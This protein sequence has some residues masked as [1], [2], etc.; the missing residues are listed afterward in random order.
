[1]P[2]MPNG[3][4]TMARGQ[5]SSLSS[6][7]AGKYADKEGVGVC[8]TCPSGQYQADTGKSKCME[9]ANIGKLKTNN[10]DY[11]GCVDN[12][13]LFSDTFVVSMFSDG[14]ALYVSFGMSVLFVVVCGLMQHK[15]EEA[16]EGS[17]G[18]IRR[19]QVLIKSA[20]QGFSFCSEIFAIGM[21]DAPQIAAVILV[22]EACTLLLSY[23]LVAMFGKTT[24]AGDLC[25]LRHVEGFDRFRLRLANIPAVVAVTVLSFD[26]TI[27]QMLLLKNVDFYQK[28]NGFPGLSLM[29]MFG[30]GDTAVC[31]KCVVSD[32][33]LV[34]IP[35]R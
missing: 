17:L 24:W 12:K 7:S 25:R 11:T 26:V 10:E 4:I 29:C 21:S 19:V 8:T 5:L 35:R 28:S 22:F 20:P 13:A 14:I 15:R 30:C 31:S 23:I 34:C 3:Q 2:S 16:P 33:L 27:V 1:M 6:V 18:Q 9:C 32:D